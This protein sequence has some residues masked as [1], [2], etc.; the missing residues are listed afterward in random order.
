MRAEADAQ[1]SLEEPW[2]MQSLRQSANRARPSS[3]PPWV[4]PAPIREE[5]FGLE[6]LERHAESLAM[7]Q[8]VTARPPKVP[9][10]DRRLKSNATALLADYRSGAA[11]AEKGGDLVPA[12]EWLLDNY[13]LV[14][15][16]IREIREFLPA[17][18]YRELPKL[19]AGPLAGYPRVFG[20]AWAFIAHTDSHIDPQMLRCFIKAYQR[21]QPLMIGEL[22]AVAITLRIVLVENLRRL[23]AQ[24]V[25]GRSERADADALADRLLALGGATAALDADIATRSTAPC[26]RSSP[27]N[28]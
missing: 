24:I 7:A 20:L 3:I 4:G 14:D 26:R 10:L 11:I 21:V 16:Q 8:Q 27:R 15:K 2:T 12:A 19:A 5:R 18:Y 9:P 1:T 17:G 13:H 6:R 22:W 28:W 23:S 25:L